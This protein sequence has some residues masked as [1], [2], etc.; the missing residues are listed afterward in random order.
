MT[1]VNKQKKKFFVNAHYLEFVYAF[2]NDDFF[3]N[4]LY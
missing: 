2:Y 4:L 3:I 1:F